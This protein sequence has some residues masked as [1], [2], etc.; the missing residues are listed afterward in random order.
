M[1]F[2]ACAAHGEK[3]QVRVAVLKGPTG[4]GAAWLMNENEAGR[5]E[6]RYEFT[7]AGTPDAF[8]G[9]LITGALDI[10]ALP[11][12]A[13]AMLAEKSNGAVQAVGIS[14]LGVLYVLERGDSV[15]SVADLAGK[16]V[17]CAVRGS[18]AEAIAGRLFGDD[19]EMRYVSEHSEAVA[20]AAQGR[21]DLV[22]I[23]EPFV[24]SLLARDI[25][26][27]IAIDLTAAWHES[28]AGEL[29]MGG[30]AVRTGFAAEN[31]RAVE[32]FLAEYAA[33]VAYTN[34]NPAEAAQLIEQYDILQA[35][36][37]E[38]AIPRANMV[39]ITGDAMKAALEAYYAVLFAD[40]PAL[41]G[42]ALPAGAFY[43]AP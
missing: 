3:T 4:L 6:N 22:L 1:L 2:T 12:N 28:G 40:D 32:A 17:V 15:Q 20:L 11:S 21:A 19:A 13:I 31:P 42:G 33:S 8:I 10:A 43:Y 7:L 37:A 26:F 16:T 35:E 24:T 38:A 41:I 34:E 29:P 39:L 18:T 9:Q 23:P 5:T 25:G 30:I 36:I 14:T 27:R